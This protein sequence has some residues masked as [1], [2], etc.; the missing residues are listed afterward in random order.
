[1]TNPKST[2]GDEVVVHFIGL[3]PSEAIVEFEEF[4]DLAILILS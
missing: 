1:M 2:Q 3:A 4:E